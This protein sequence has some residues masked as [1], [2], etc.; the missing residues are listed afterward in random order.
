IEEAAGEVTAPGRHADVEVALTLPSGVITGDA[1]SGIVLT[2]AEG[3]KY[4]L[5]HIANIWR[6]TE[7]GWNLADLPLAGKTITNIR[8][9]TLGNV[10]D[11]PVELKIPETAYVLMNIPYDKFYEAELDEKALP[12]DAVSSST[13]NKPR[14]VNLVGG[15]YHVN[16]DGSDITG[17]T[18]PVYVNLADLAAFHEVKDEDKVEITVTLR[19]ETSTTAF[20]GKDALFESM[21]YSFYR[22]HEKPARY[23][24]LTMA[25]GEPSFS[26]V[27]GR[28]TSVE[29]VTGNVTLAAHHTDV[30]IALE[31]TTGMEAGDPVSGIILTTE[32]GEKVALRHLANIWRGTQIGW[33]YEDNDLTGKTITNIRYLTQQDVIDYPVSIHVHKL[34]KVDA[35]DP[36]YTEEGNLEYYRCESDEAHLFL[37]E[38]GTT[39]T[40]LEE[41]TVQ[42]L[43]QPLGQVKNLQTSVRVDEGAMK[44][45]FDKVKGAT[46]YQVAYRNAGKSWKKVRTGGKR[47]V[48]LSDLE[49]GALIDVRVRALT[50]K[51]GDVAYGKYST[52]A[53]RWITKTTATLTPKKAGLK[54][55][56]NALEGAVKY[57]LRYSTDSSFGVENRTN[58][59]NTTR[60]LKNLKA[61]KVYYVRVRAY[62]D[63]EGTR[64]LSAWGDTVTNTTK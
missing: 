41:V 4:A 3:A 32:D 56:V 10:I 2:D 22:L 31:G 58:V 47:T 60:T 19:G 52:Q 7:I 27:S 51:E 54:V 1:V 9:Y 64:Y 17:V 43:L 11:Y 5:R 12:V 45:T 35:K 30:E 37:D 53:H 33:N 21:S 44:V 16:A 18:Y 49:K 13:L 39:P 46:D 61:G 38:A 26:A 24:T 62:K 25:E 40:T 55:K 57:R 42:K 34:V 48:M 8:Y 29:G 59:K 23:K 15:S 36:T 20:A 50:E 14:A 28:S 63:Y 6:G